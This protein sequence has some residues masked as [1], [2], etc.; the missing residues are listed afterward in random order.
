[1]LKP[2]G[3][4][5]RVLKRTQSRCGRAGGG[6][7]AEHRRVTKRAEERRSIRQARGAR[8]GR[9]RSPKKATDVRLH[10]R[11]TLLDFHELPSAQEENATV[12]ERVEDMA[13]TGHSLSIR[14]RDWRGTGHVGRRSARQ[15]CVHRSRS[16]G[17]SSFSP[18]AN[19]RSRPSNLRYLFSS[20]LV[21]LAA[22]IYPYSSPNT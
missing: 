6:L 7:R 3:A 21:H 8:W 11:G 4:A 2:V 1:M 12:T 20:S 15:R 22:H 18:T 10:A 16:L 13:V 19:W 14:C 9:L 17:L 5:T